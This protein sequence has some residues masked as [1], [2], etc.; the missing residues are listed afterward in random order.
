[1]AHRPHI[2]RKLR[3]GFWVFGALLLIEIVE[4]LLGMGLGRG[5]WPYLAIL[6]IIGAWPIVRYFM[7]LPQLWRREE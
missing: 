4:Y 7:H 5:A 6:A 3:C 2:R 1:M